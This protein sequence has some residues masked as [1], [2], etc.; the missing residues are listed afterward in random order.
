MTHR[1]LKAN[2][3]FQVKIDKMNE[4]WTSSLSIGLLGCGSTGAPP[5]NF[6]DNFHLP[7]TALGLKRN[8]VVVSGDG[9]LYLNG[10][11]HS[12]SRLNFAGFLNRSCPFPAA[13]SLLSLAIEAPAL[14]AQLG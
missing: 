3:V 12:G 7:I 13:S 4:R 9:G 2:E 5:N 1:P 14:S 6:P 11:R 10:H 8:A